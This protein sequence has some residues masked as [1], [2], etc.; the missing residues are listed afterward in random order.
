MAAELDGVVATIAGGER[1]D[2]ALLAAVP[3]LRVIARAGV[4]FDAVDLE[5]ATKRAG[6]VTITPPE[7]F[8]SETASA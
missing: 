8:S 4:G 6:A 1:Y 3:T 2:E 7:A 5:A